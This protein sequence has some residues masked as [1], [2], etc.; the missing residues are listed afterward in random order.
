MLN[1]SAVSVRNNRQN[2]NGSATQAEAKAIEVLN[3]SLKNMGNDELS[4]LSE[5]LTISRNLY[6]HYGLPGL[7]STVQKQLNSVSAEIASRSAV[8]LN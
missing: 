6:S 2:F 1:V 5:T 3:A 7:E 8:S 4:T